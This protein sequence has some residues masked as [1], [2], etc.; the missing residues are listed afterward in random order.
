MVTNTNPSILLHMHSGSMEP[1]VVNLQPDDL[2]CALNACNI[3]KDT[4]L[5]LLAATDEEK[6]QW[7]TMLFCKVFANYF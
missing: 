6:E 1:T 2:A 5:P 7:E 3:L 4:D